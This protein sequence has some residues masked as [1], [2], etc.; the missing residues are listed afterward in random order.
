MYPGVVPT[1]HWFKM[2]YVDARLIP[3][4]VVDDGIARYGAMRSLPCQAVSVELDLLPV[5]VKPLCDN[6]VSAWADAASKNMASGVVVDRVWKIV[7]LPPV[8][9]VDIAER[10]TLDPPPALIVPAG[11]RCCLA[12]STGADIE[13]C[14]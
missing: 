14:H 1:L 4:P 8:V 7:V 5:S 6:A 2:L 13:R 3:A 10:F 9:P 12:A 11:K